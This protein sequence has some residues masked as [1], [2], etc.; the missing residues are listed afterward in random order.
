MELIMAMIT[1][2]MNAV[3]ESMKIRIIIVAIANGRIYTLN[4]LWRTIKAV[5]TG[6]TTMMPKSKIILRCSLK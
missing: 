5:N 3:R 6:K 4:Q 2:P 1:V